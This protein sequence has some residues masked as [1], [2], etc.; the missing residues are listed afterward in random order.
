[1]K[2]RELPIT[3]DAEIV[4]TKRVIDD[5]GK[6]AKTTTFTVQVTGDEF[7]SLDALLLE[8]KERTLARL[9]Q[10]EEEQ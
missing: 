8:L 1:M 9:A 2:P 3:Y 4:L 6:G 10:I 5:V 7:V